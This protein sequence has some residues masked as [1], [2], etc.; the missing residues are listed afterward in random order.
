MKPPIILLQQR[1]FGQKINATFDFVVQNFKPLAISLLYIA[2]PLSL[3]GGFFMGS[4]QSGILEMQKSVLE[5]GSSSFDGI[6]Q[7]VGTVF[8][9]SFFLI[10]ANIISSLVIGAY[11]LEYE[12]GN[13]NITPEIVWNR[14]KGYIGKALIFNFVMGIAVVAGIVFFLLPGIYLGVT[15][16]LMTMI[17]M[18]EN[19]DLGDT[20]RRCFYL[21]K[22]K[23]WSTFGLLFVM[24]I[25]SSIIGYAFQIPTLILTIMSSLQVKLANTEVL[26]TISGVI[27]TVG[28]GL[29][30]SLVLIAIVFQYYNLVERREG[31]GI[32]DAIDN[33]GKTDTPRTDLREEEF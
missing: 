2:G 22:D 6:Y 33:I 4:Y 8:L 3:V 19:L 15:L 12:A 28:G 17:L 20:F 31:S 5:S 18:R 23:W 27:G 29:V 24:G 7:M 1:D 30:R 11:F 13:R 21:I 14:L 9:L 32:L 16:S 10:L 26:M 25:V